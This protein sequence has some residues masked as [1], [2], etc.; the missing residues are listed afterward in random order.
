MANEVVKYKVNLTEKP[1]DAK[2]L[3]IESQADVKNPWC[4][5]GTLSVDL[6]AI[7]LKSTAA[8]KTELMKR[9]LRIDAQAAERN[10]IL[11]LLGVKKTADN[12]GRKIVYDRAIANGVSAEVAA[13]ISGYKSGK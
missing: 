13:D 11:E 8:E 2:G 3:T 12:V 1:V 7:I 9:S 4:V 6:D 10:R 5:K